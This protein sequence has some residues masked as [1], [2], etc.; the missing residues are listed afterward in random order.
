MKKSIK[1]TF[2]KLIGENI[3]DYK[4]ESNKSFLK[5]IVFNDEVTK[6]SSNQAVHSWV[7]LLFTFTLFWRC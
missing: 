4:F 6:E 5:D 2:L 1:R 7:K 3:D